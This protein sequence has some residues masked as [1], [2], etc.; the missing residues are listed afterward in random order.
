MKKIDIS[1]IV[2]IYGVEKYIERCLRSLF[3]QTKSDG[4]EFIL[5]N[6]ATPDNS[7]VVVESIIKDY[8]NL[9]IK[10]VNHAI[11]KGLAVARQ[12][13]VDI[14]SGEFI[15]H[16]DS[17][18]WCE[19]T[20]LEELYDFAVAT[21]SDVVVCD[22]YKNILD[23]EIYE[24]QMV[25]EDPLEFYALVL[26][27]KAM[28]SLCNKFIKR[29]V[30]IDNDIKSVPSI[31]MGEDQILCAQLMCKGRP[32][33]DYLEKAYFH[34]C[35]RNG[36]YMGVVS[37]KYLQESIAGTDIIEQMIREENLIDRF[38][39]GLIVKKLRV[40]LKCLLNSSGDRQR[41]YATIYPET[42]EYIYSHTPAKLPYKVA[43]KQATFGRVFMF[44]VIANAVRYIHKVRR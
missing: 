10:I 8:P 4:V 14:S 9:D 5:V 36:S 7:M 29:S 42:N 33:I 3:T 23:E 39:E 25:S 19:S 15:M 30:L 11:N 34:Y 22:I 32:Q 17:D 37:D 35:I 28:P 24:K 41:E 40:K 13:G 43:L 12:S 21:N 27:G 2:P 18:D 44:N 26:N 1:L 38:H 16:I 31:N 6:D 20:M